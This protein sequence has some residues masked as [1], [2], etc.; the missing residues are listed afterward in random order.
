MRAA[1]DLQTYLFCFDPE[2]GGVSDDFLC[3]EVHT[4]VEEVETPEDLA[5]LWREASDDQRKGFLWKGKEDSEEFMGYLLACA[6]VIDHLRKNLQTDRQAE[7][8]SLN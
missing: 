8:R 7:L 4:M 2:P 3:R 6:L 5:R 1:L